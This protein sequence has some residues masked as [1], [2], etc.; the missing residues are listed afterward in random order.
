MDAPGHMYYLQ[1]L[2]LMLLMGVCTVWLSRLV[3]WI[4]L[5]KKL[6]RRK[7][8][9]TLIISLGLSYLLTLLAWFYWPNPEQPMWRIFFLP[10]VVA[11]VLIL[12]GTILIFKK[13][14][15]A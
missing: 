6:P 2:L 5:R 14:K 13:Q 12:I 15:R 11:E 8:A 10:A 3:Q 4:L 7:V 1:M 9:Q